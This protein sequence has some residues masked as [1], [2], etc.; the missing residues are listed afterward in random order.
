M[1]QSGPNPSSSLSIRAKVKEVSATESR[2]LRDRQIA[3]LGR[4]L[5]RAALLSKHGAPS[6]AN[7]SPDKASRRGKR[8]R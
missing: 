8:R 4:L 6:P 3:A 5:R 7:G 1:K 2:D